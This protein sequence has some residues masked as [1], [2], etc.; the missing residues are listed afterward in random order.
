MKEGMKNMKIGQFCSVHFEDG[1]LVGKI[2][3]V[4]EN[5]ITAE[6]DNAIVEGIPKE[7]VTPFG[8]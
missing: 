3:S 4:D 5:T 8:Y 7:I 1:C 6:F 2:I